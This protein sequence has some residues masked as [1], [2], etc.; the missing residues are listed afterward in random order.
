MDIRNPLRASS[1]NEGT[2]ERSFIFFGLFLVTSAMASN[3]QALEC[4][5]A[6]SVRLKQPANVIRA[7]TRLLRERGAGAVPD[8]AHALRKKYPE[9]GHGEITNY[10]I[11]IYCPIVNTNLALSDDEKRQKVLRFAAQVRARSL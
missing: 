9:S 10:L 8:I 5:D 6:H 4:P 2:R 3:A 11:S 7:E 1:D